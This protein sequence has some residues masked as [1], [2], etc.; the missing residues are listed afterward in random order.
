LRVRR[1]ND[2]LD[3]F[4]I[5]LTPQIPAQRRERSL[6]SFGPTLGSMAGN[7]PRIYDAAKV[8]FSRQDERGEFE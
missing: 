4:L 2:S 7:P 5:L 1:E 6:R 8:E 3:R